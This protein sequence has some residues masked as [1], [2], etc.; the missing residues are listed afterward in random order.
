MDIAFIREKDKLVVIYL[1]DINVFSKSDKKHCCL[2]R[3]VF[4]KCKQFG[5]SLNPKKSLFAMKDGKL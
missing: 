2:L 4:L 1:D 5:I 3:K